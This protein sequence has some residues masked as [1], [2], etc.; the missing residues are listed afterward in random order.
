MLDLFKKT[1]AAR[2]YGPQKFV[3]GYEKSSWS[4]FSVRLNVQPLTADELQ[5]L[6]EGERAVKRYKAFGA[7]GL[8][9]SNVQDGT[10]ADLVFIGD[11]WYEV[12]SSNDWHHLPILAH[13][14]VELVQIEDQPA[15][16]EGG[17]T[18]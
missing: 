5:A 18:P 17:S 11:R 8:R 6:P 14:Y 1:Y 9:T 12:R 7:S 10:K 13:D 3:D 4:D 16:P 15:A 2:R